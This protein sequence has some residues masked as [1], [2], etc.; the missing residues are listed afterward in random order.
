MRRL[1]LLPLVL[2][3]IISS[4]TLNSQTLTVPCGNHVLEANDRANIPNYD[5][6]VLSFNKQIKNYIASS[7]MSSGNLTSAGALYNIPVVVH[8]IKTAGMPYGTGTNI[9]YAQIQSQINAL[10]VAFAANQANYQ[11]LYGVDTKIQFC[12]ARNTEPSSLNWSLDPSNTIEYGVMR[13]N[14]AD[15]NDPAINVNLPAFQSLT[16]LPFVTLT[17]NASVNSFNKLNYLNI[18]VVDQI[19]VNS[20][21]GSTTAA[22]VYFN[23]NLL[24]I[25]QP[26]GII[27]DSEYFGENTLTG[28][29]Y[30]LIPGKEDG[31][32]LVHETGHF[33][34]LQHTFYPNA[35]LS[36]IPTGSCFGTE[37]AG[38]LNDPCDLNGDGIC[39]IAPM[40]SGFTGMCNPLVRPN[41][42]YEFYVPACGIEDLPND[43]MSYELD[44]CRN[45]FTNDQK[46]RMWA[47]LNIKWSNLWTTSN[48]IYTG[49]IGTDGC[50]A[51]GALNTDIRTSVPYACAGKPVTFTTLTCL[52]GNSVVD[53]NWTLT[54]SSLPAYH[55]TNCTSANPPSVI[56]STPGIYNISLTVTDAMGNTQTAAVQFLVVDC[57]INPGKKSQS[58]WHFGNY[59]SLNFATGIPVKNDDTFNPQTSITNFGALPV[60]ISDNTGNDLYYSNA[61]DVWK[62]AAGVPAKI[63]TGGPLPS[64]HFTGGLNNLGQPF[65]NSA[66]N[67]ITV[68]APG[69]PNR[70]YIF[71]TPNSAFSNGTVL[72]TFMA[73]YALIDL[74]GSGSVVNQGLLPLPACVSN[75]KLTTCIT[76]IPHCNGKDY[77]IIFYSQINRR[78]YVYSVTQN[79]VTNANF[80][81]LEPNPYP[82]CTASFNHNPITQ[83]QLQLKGSPLGNKLAL[84]GDNLALYDFNSSTGVI[85]NEVITPHYYEA[86]KYYGCSFSPNGQYV[87]ATALGFAGGIT[88]ND[89]IIKYTIATNSNS[90]ILLPFNTAPTN[91]Q[92]GPNDHIYFAN[93]TVN[94]Y[95]NEIPNPDNATGTIAIQNN[96]SLIT[97]SGAAGSPLIMKNMGSIVNNMDA[98]TP[99]FVA[100]DFTVLNSIAGCPTYVFDIN[101]C[102]KNY[103]VTWNF[104]DGSPTGSGSTATHVFNPGTYVVTATLSGPLVTFPLVI[105]HNVTVTQPGAPNANAGAPQTICLGA[106]ATLNGSGTGT[107]Q[108]QPAGS[109]L[110]CY[111]CSN[112]AA[113][114]LVTTTY[115]LNV[116]NTCGTQSSSVLI[117]VGPACIPVC[118]NCIPVA[119]SGVVAGGTLNGNTYCLNNNVT[120]TGNVSITNCEFKMTAGVLIT[121]APS[122]VLTITGSHFYSC[123]DMWK[124]IV[125]QNGGRLAIRSS[126][127]EDAVTAVD[128]SNNTQT[129]NVLT[130]SNSTFNKNYK[131]ISIN[132]Y[133]QPVTAYPFTVTNSVFT[134]RNIPFT[135]NSL[136]FPSAAVVGA[137]ASNAGQPFSNGYIDNV[138][139]AQATPVV[140]FL[141]APFANTKPNAGIELNTVGLTLNAQTTAPVYYEFSIGA[142]G[143]KNIFDNLSYGINATDANVS[144]YNN[145]FQNTVAFGKGGTI[146]GI[147]INAYATATGN[148]R[149]QA[150]SF[151]SGLPGLGNRF[152]DCSRAI[153]TYNIF[154]HVIT[155][156]DFRSTQNLSAPSAFN[157]ARGQYGVKS[158]TNRYRVYNVSHNT[159][160]NVANGIILDATFGPVSFPNYPYP[161]V[162]YSGSVNADNNTI[163]SQIGSAVV[164]GNFVSN[165]IAISDIISSPYVIA[166]VSPSATSLIQAANNTITKVYRG[167]AYLNWQKA[168]SIINS[169]N[170]TLLPDLISAAA[171]QFGISLSGSQANVNA[172]SVRNN[173]VTGFGITANTAVYGIADNISSSIQVSCNTTANTYNGIAFGGSCPN[174]NFSKNYM[175]GHKYGFALLNNGVIGQQGNTANPQDNEWTGT[176]PSGNFKTATIN[177]TSQTSKLYLRTTATGV[178]NPN[179][180]SFVQFPGVILIDDYNIGGP[181]PSLI[182]TTSNPFTLPCLASVPWPG[183]GGGT[184]QPQL[185]N[186]VAQLE[187]IVL[188]LINYQTN[189]IESKT[190]NK[191]QVYRLLKEDQSL[192]TGSAV[193]QSFYTASQST[194][195]KTF[196]DVETGIGSGNAS[197]AVSMNAAISPA[198]NVETGYKS[199]YDLAI[200]QLQHSLTAADTTAL[201]TLAYSCPFTAGPMVYRARALLNVVYD[202][203]QVYPDNCNAAASSRLENMQDRYSANDP[204][205]GFDAVLFPNPG[206]INFN[207]ATFGLTEG[208]V[209]INISDVTGKQVY[210]NTLSVI[211]ALAIFNIDIKNGIYF[212]KITNK[213]KIITKKLI[214]QQ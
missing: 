53:W 71:N 68:P 195:R 201:T 178:Y 87:Y 118:N 21:T 6:L 162:Q 155:Y 62:V 47:T 151:I 199:F 64:F 59:V 204:G 156:N 163:A 58:N 159:L 104:G 166:P 31:K 189:S 39:D 25:N 107:Y 128:I 89:F 108:W 121:I 182:P 173:N 80:T 41:S 123:G 150:T 102:Y 188:D 137:A 30:N 167:I 116:T 15:I 18:W 154:E 164:T 26:E 136:V 157:N 200:K 38:S 76:A 197:S 143:G 33:F 11:G 103:T 129:A 122:A 181:A 65:E 32:T 78:F 100:P 28:N 142:L 7:G 153:N 94:D 125:I 82:S 133:T 9:S 145:V 111:T 22:G 5:S 176:W 134:C 1:K 152:T 161:N 81:S 112:P 61:V 8:V 175:S 20:F 179:G 23:N 75:E 148:F 99:P 149:L 109:G 63:N 165:A 45:T 208:E 85:S 132:N 139:Y 114:P 105:T 193:L 213:D 210:E 180:S 74:S 191:N 36:P 186:F 120:V 146:G 60:S 46:L 98:I 95:L 96:V 171:T 184:A 160:Y 177:S 29:S 34:G 86:G 55:S 211:N 4:L 93:F 205:S 16:Y 124:G 90:A 43:Y 192:M 126:M 51:A 141:K 49:L 183:G 196:D 203:Y 73:G 3:C 57:I 48:L 17:N 77:W 92:L 170:I 147:G 37:A 202:R 144:S 54:G 83:N 209:E 84:S 190:I 168:N 158:I 88:V 42:C 101:N 69:F 67:S 12:L 198:D 19:M 79:G 138:T 140:S 169:N 56:F 172:S 35:G 40:S 127:I 72:S 174:T 2:C 14:A 110:S 70:Y 187:A 212:V 185:Q 214:V 113:T 44:P 91:M 52:S 131:S 50:V 207:I 97:A 10:N 106:S 24:N 13:Y 135:Q 194:S 115:I 117:T 27:M 130:V 66:S 119:A 206:T